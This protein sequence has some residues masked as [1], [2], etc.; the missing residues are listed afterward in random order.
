[1]KYQIVFPPNPLMASVEL[2][3]KFN[4]HVYGF[5]DRED[6]IPKFFEET[7]IGHYDTPKYITRIWDIEGIETIFLM[8]DHV[9]ILMKKGFPFSW[10]EI[11][12][13]VVEIM[14]EELSPDTR[15]E[16]KSPAIRPSEEYLKI[17]REEGRTV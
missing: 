12:P 10:D 9:S 8:P 15:M 13:V 17:L 4:N 3:E 5:D 6:K 16:E 14:Q 11:L 2:T 1:M 7:F